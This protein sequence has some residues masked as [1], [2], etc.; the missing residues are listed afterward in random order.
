MKQ[1]VKTFS[2]VVAVIIIIAVVFGAGYIVGKLPSSEAEATNQSGKEG[3]DLKL[4]GETEKMVVTVDEV[5]TKIMEIGELT[6]CQGDYT[7]TKG[8]DFTRY[9]LD[10]IPIPGTTNHI[11]LTCSGVVKAGYNLQDVVVKVDNESK[12]IYVSLP[13]AKINSN[14]LLW[15]NSMINNEQNNILN[16]IG[17]EQYQTMIEEIKEEGLQ[18]AE[19]NGLFKTVE[20]NAKNLI[21]NFLGCFVNYTVVFM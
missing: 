20:K 5:E 14:Q 4:P 18:D 17:F 7:V 16:P 6:S 13:D 1:Y 3:F 8:Q 10:D 12:T 21:T 9:M 19:N 15:D 2:N 11:E